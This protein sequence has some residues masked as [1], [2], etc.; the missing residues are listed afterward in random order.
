MVCGLGGLFVF[1]GY[2]LRVA[3]SV[4]APEL[5][6][7]FGVGATILGNL[8]AMYFFAFACIQVPAG[9]ML[10]RFGPRR[11]LT[12]AIALCA[13][14]SVLFAAA[15]S[16][17]TAYAGRLLIGAASGFSLVGAL[18]LTAVLFPPRR[19]AFAA[20]LTA[21]LGTMGGIMGQAPLA[22]LVLWAGWRESM[23][24]TAI[25][26]TALAFAFWFVARDHGEVVPQRAAD[27]PSGI[28]V[29]GRVAASSQVRLVACA[30]ALQAPIPLAFGGLWGIP[31][32]MR[33]HGLERPAA[34]AAISLVLVSYAVATPLLGWW[35]D[36]IGRRKLPMMVGACTTLAAMMAL[37]YGPRWP[38]PVAYILCFAT[39][40]GISAM[41]L[42][43]SVGREHGPPGATGTVVGII[44]M[45]IMFVGAVFQPLIGWLL[46]LNWDG[47]MEAGA[48][49][50]PVEAYEKAFLLLLASQVLALLTMTM[51]RETHCRPAT[52][53]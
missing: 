6:R 8:L 10:D 23:I 24:G 51:V 25:A 30:A 7:D 29:V 5:M 26:G 39:G 33:A 38:L 36:R 13:M 3:P 28:G 4:M 22:A 19:F 1:Y 50:Y 21:A 43:M 18:K 20:G 17:A 31:Y 16:L 40:I 11:V 2:F 49:V 15:D 46:D 34:A 35:S 42:A 27:T 32:M 14:G 47:H 52:E 9:M 37:I 53:A 12:A 48:R 41:F 44:N 45:S